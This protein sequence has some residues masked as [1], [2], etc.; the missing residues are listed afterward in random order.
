MIAG[1]ANMH[2]MGSSSTGNFSAYGP[3]R[4]P[5]DTERCPGGS[6]SGPGSSV[7]GRLVGGAVGADGIGSIRYPSAY[8]GITGLKPTFG[9]S[10][11]EGHH[12][13]ATTTIVSGPMCG[14]AASCRLLGSALFGEE[15]PPSDAAGLRIG[16]RQAPVFS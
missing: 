11:M 12:V 8:C 1:V 9:R 14:D 5:W 6:S 3:A 13:K 2:E 7:G 4:N 15:L 16:I 10:A